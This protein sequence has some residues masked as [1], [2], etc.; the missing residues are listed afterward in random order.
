MQAGALNLL[1]DRLTAVAEEVRAALS[2]SIVKVVGTIHDI[3]SSTQDSSLIQSALNALTAVCNTL[4]QGEEASVSSTLPLVLRCSA[5]P[6]I[7]I[8]ALSAVLS[9]S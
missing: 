7:R 1:A 8:T 2:W 4:A 5:A 9:F 6:P 3:L